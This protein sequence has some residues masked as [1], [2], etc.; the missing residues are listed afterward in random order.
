MQFVQRFAVHEC[1]MYDFLIS[2]SLCFQLG[3][4]ITISLENE[5]LGTGMFH[6]HIYGFT[7]SCFVYL[8]FVSSVSHV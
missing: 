8:G 2:C 7:I 1:N 6:I 5:P 3:C 4:K